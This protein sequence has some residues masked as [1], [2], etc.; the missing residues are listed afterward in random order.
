V[1][2]GH[3]ERSGGGLTYSDSDELAAAVDR[4]RSAPALRRELGERG[5]GY[6]DRFFRWPA[7]IERYRRFLD[8]IL[9]ETAS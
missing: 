2:V 7:L 3:C 8:G 6:V 9:K 1:L 4:L 5:S